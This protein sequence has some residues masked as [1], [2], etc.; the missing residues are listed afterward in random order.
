MKKR[1]A[2]RLWNV[3]RSL[4]EWPN[5]P[6]YKPYGK[7]IEPLIVFSNRR[8][9]QKII[10]CTDCDICDCCNIHFVED[11]NFRCI[12]SVTDSY[13][14]EKITQFFGISLSELTELFGEEGCNNARTAE[15]YAYYIENLL[16]IKEGHPELSEKE[17]DQDLLEANKRLNENNERISLDKLKKLYLSR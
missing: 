15:E 6:K 3:V 12:C 14:Q 13:F 8:D 5:R 17:D 9:L 7:E 10:V 4:R 2:K 11:G 16:L 1:Q